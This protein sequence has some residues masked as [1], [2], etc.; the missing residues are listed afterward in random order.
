MKAVSN[1]A[2]DKSLHH[3]TQNLLFLCDSEEFSCKKL[4]GVFSI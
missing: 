3:V 1:S 4:H 2:T